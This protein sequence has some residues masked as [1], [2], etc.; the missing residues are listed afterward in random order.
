[1]KNSARS[2]IRQKFDENKSHSNVKAASPKGLLYKFANKIAVL[3]PQGEGQRLDCQLDK[4]SPRAD[5]VMRQAKSRG[6]EL[7]VR[8]SVQ[9][10]Q[11]VSLFYFVKQLITPAVA[12]ILSEK[13]GCA[14][15]YRRI[16]DIGLRSQAN[17][18][19]VALSDLQI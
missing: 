3:F 6:G 15:R 12:Q 11:D 16:L 4:E 18:V 5:H 8:T 13:T 14:I 19:R 1:M 2:H 9:D 17:L 10:N 7:I